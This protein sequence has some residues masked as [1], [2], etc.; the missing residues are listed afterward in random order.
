M[1]FKTF[2]TASRRIALF[3]L[4]GP[5]AVTQASGQ[6]EGWPR[7]IDTAKGLVVL[8]QPQLDVFEGNHLEARAAV[9]VIPTGKTEPVFGAV[10]LKSLVETD[11]DTR[12]V[13]IL[14][15]EVPRV[16]FPGSTAEQEQDLSQFLERQIP[17]WDMSLSLDRLLA[18]MELVDKR[19]M[20][21]EGF[22][23]TPPKIL[24]ATYP[25]ILVIIDGEPQLRD[26]EGTELKHVVNTT[27]LLVFVPQNGTYYLYA[28]NEQWYTARQ[29]AGPWQITPSVP[30]Q[31]AA[32]APIEEEREAERE[33]QQAAA[34][35]GETVEAAAE[36]SQP[37][38]ILVATEPTELI[39]TDG[40]PKWGP[41]EGNELLYVTNSESDV[42][43]EVE[44]Q[45]YFVLLSGRWFASKSLEGPWSFV[46][47][48]GLPESFAEIPAESD[49]AHLR[50]WVAGTEEAEEAVLEASVPQTST[51]KRDATIQVEYDGNP[52]FE[53]VEETQLEYAVNTS[54]QVLRYGNKYYCANEAVWY[55][56]DNP[57]GP[58]KV[59]VAIPEEIQKIPPS[60]PVYNVKYVYIYDS[61]PEVVYVGYYPGYTHSYVYNGCVVYGTGWYYSPW[62][63]TYYYPRPATWGFHVRWNP[64]RGWGFGF[65]YSTGRFTF[66]I[67]F[68]GWR[69]WYRRGL[70]G[71]RGHRGYRRGYN[72]GYRSGARAGYRAG[73]R[74]Q[75][76]YRR[77]QN[78]GR[79]AATTRARTGQQPRTSTTRQNNVAADR[80]GNVAQR[81]QSGDWQSRAGSRPSSSTS[82][83]L[84][85]T[86]NARQKGTARTQR[87]R[88]GGGRRGGGRRR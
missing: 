37:P 75:N 53:K 19:R 80:N 15:V 20:V 25:A 27:F 32:L 81:T 44:S 9:S 10:W 61:T 23:N 36:P 40:D 17:N 8:Y 73:S 57:L 51:I 26:V 31:V 3:L 86:Q 84:N 43:M 85:R 74:N 88:G 5:F 54:Y 83:S 16:R 59:A 49:L 82:Q 7:E 50:V 12:T 62:W 21:D 34:A 64:W 79:N 42:L 52:R 69:G 18:M 56:A 14:D 24:L 72:R 47:S 60:S 38:A 46:A 87:S 2:Q 67:G 11:L 29:V 55:E 68:G 35:E 65:S 13:E 6:E 30:S 1:M 22:D 4:L 78:A 76:I 41:I 58:W 66:G 70:W 71:P 48:D 33:A 63:G 77:Q 28:G 39:V 45:R